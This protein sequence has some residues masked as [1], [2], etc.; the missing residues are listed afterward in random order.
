VTGFFEAISEF[1]TRGPRPL[2]LGNAISVAKKI[3]DLLK[4]A[5]ILQQQAGEG[6]GLV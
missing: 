2:R 1:V 5:N 4:V 3:V 6:N